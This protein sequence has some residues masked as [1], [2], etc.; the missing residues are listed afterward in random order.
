MRKS[1]SRQT[2]SVQGIAT[3]WSERISVSI[4][5][6]GLLKIILPQKLS[7]Y[8]SVVT[9]ISLVSLLDGHQVNDHHA[10]W[11]FVNFEN[12]RMGSPDVH[13]IDPHFGMQTFHIGCAVR[14]FKFAEVV[15]DM[16]P[17]LFRVFFKGLYDTSFD[18]YIHIDT[19]A[20]LSII[21][22]PFHEEKI[23]TGC[24]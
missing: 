19:S 10:V 1:K 14:I 6:Q 15:E 5:N 24:S 18:L 21:C 9:T 20:I 12:Y 16:H 7:H 23:S 2:F 17:D 8:Y 11:F 22:H 4:F 13:T 3:Q